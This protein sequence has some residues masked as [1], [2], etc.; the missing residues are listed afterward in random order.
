MVMS[1]DDDPDSHPFWYARVLGIYHANVMDAGARSPKAKRMEFLWVR[2]FGMDPEWSGGPSTLRLD[3]VGYIPE[4]DE[5]GAFGFVD[6][7]HV[8]RA[9]H[10]IPA[11]NLGKT[12]TLLSYSTMRDFHDGD[13]TN[14]YIMR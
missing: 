14:Y 1:N 6:P 7:S 12:D 10:L 3:R 4:H 2:W 5:S 9:C 13:W 8:L 11:F